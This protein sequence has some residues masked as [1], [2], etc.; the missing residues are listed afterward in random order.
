[1]LESNKANFDETQKKKLEMKQHVKQVKKLHYLQHLGFNLEHSTRASDAKN[2]LRVASL[3]E[4]IKVM[5]SYLHTEIQMNIEEEEKSLVNA[6]HRPAKRKQLA[7]Y[8]SKCH[9]Y[10]EKP[11]SLSYIT[12]EVKARTKLKNLLAQ[13]NQKKETDGDKIKHEKF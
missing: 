13:Y 11:K 12:P 2:T 9:Q 5:D 7:Q 8:H 3:D 1:M 10:V 6:L 4:K